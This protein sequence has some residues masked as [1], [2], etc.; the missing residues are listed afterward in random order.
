MVTMP[1]HRCVGSGLIANENRAFG[2]LLG[3]LHYH[4]RVAILHCAEGKM[5]AVLIDGSII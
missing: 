1:P 4:Y 5:L 3:R 2:V